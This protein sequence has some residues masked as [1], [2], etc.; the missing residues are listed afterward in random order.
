MI[1]PLHHHTAQGAKASAAIIVVTIGAPAMFAV[2]VARI[3]AD[4]PLPR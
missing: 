2:A 3:F 1:D 4:D